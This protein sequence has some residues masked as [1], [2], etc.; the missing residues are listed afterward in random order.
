MVTNEPG[1][2]SPP[3][4]ST[5]L[6]RA[7]TG[8]ML[9]VFI[10]G[11]VLGAGIYALVG[12]IAGEVGG[13]IWLPL[14]VALLMAMLTA[15]SY[16]ELVTKYPRAGGAAVFAKRAYRR[17][18][19]SFMVGFSMLA[20]GVTSA[21]GLALAFAGDYLQVFVEIPSVAA[22]LI[23]LAAVAMLNARG[24][25]ES[26]RANLVMTVVEVS[27]LVTIIALAW[28]VLGRG[29]G[30]P[31]RVL[32]FADGATPAFAVLGAALLAFYSFVGFETSANV[33]EE[34]TDVRRVYPRAL[35]GA[36]VAAGAVYILV[37]LAVSTVID[38][39][40]LAGSSG[41]LLEVVNKA[42]A[43][44]P[45]W[46]FSLVALIAVANGALLTMIMASRLTFGMAR[47]GLLPSALSKV[48]P[49]RRT[50][51]AAI[52]ATTAVAMI[53]CATGSVAALAETVV[54][55]LLVVFVSTN[56]AVLVLRR[57]DADGDHFRV[58]T[59]FPV[60]AVVTCIVLATQQSAETW[61]RALVL[62]AI[63][64]VLYGVRRLATARS[65][66]KSATS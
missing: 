61:L 43:G 4:T 59:V 7:I 62:L 38:A 2:T 63:G 35:L 57:D 24:I 5:P 42:D 45:P 51:W 50:P 37:G 6:K 25:T 53:L 27:G 36:L 52:V 58:P 49:G 48:L 34:V 44:F 54:L 56:V 23:F 39:D 26:M 47:D 19:V 22:A 60:L 17:P 65:G 10:L 66:G 29:E 32:E 41:P 30:S 3:N 40:T 13:A 15:A 8:K 33:A 12:E 14:L 1:T 31:S 64:A 46:L 9:F 18:F 11:D 20:A 28:L 55:L 21:A 16:A